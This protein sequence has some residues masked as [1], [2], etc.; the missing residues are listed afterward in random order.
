MAFLSAK[1]TLTASEPPTELPPPEPETASAKLRISDDCVA[2]TPIAPVVAV[3]TASSTIFASISLSRTLKPKAPARV[4][5]LP[6]T[7]P[8]AIKVKAS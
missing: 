4:K 6:D 8:A 1:N 2:L 3:S 7:P 5:S